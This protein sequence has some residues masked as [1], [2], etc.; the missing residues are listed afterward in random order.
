[1]WRYSCWWWSI[2]ILRRLSARV[3]NL[4][5]RRTYSNR[6]C[7]LYPWRA[8]PNWFYSLRTYFGNFFALLWSWTTPYDN[9]IGCY[10]F[11]CLRSFKLE[12]LLL[13]RFWSL[14]FYVVLLLK[15]VV[16]KYIFFPFFRP[17]A[18]NTYLN[19]LFVIL[20]FFLRL[21]LIPSDQKIN[22]N[23]V[24]FLF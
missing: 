3:L 14:E 18:I 5:S 12:L 8:Y 20:V 2:V 17:F 15:I 4:I 19:L 16:F 7:C 1:L 6:S 11:W 9:S 10:D 13:S 23:L 21:L 22:T 24:S